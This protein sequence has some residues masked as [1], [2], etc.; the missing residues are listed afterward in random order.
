MLLDAKPEM[1]AGFA[2]IASRAAWTRETI[3]KPAIR[4]SVELVSAVRSVKC[5]QVG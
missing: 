3:T 4:H 5:A 2:N 1:S